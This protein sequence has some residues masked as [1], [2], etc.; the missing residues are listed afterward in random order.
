MFD[1]TKLGEMLS[2]FQDKAKELEEQ[3]RNLSFTAKSGGGLVSATVSGDGEVVDITIDDSLLEDKESMQILLISAINDALK[4]ME[5]N[6]KS[7]A[8]GMFD[9]ISPFGFSK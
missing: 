6:R 1:P 4:S 9:G 7:M 8:L 3:N 2:Q 5:N